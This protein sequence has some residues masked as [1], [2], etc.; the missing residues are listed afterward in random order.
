MK[1][2][3]TVIYWDAC[4]FI[5]WLQDEKDKWPLDVWQGILDAADLI[6]Q[7]NAYLL[8]ST[9]IRTEIFLGRLTLEEKQKFAG[10]LRRRN[11]Q[12][13]APDMRVTDRASTIREKYN[14]LTNKIKTPDAIHLATAIIYRADEM[15]TMDG[16]RE[17][18]KHTGLLALNANVAGYKLLIT[19]PYRRNPIIVPASPMPEMAEDENSLFA[20]GMPELLEEVEEE[21][22]ENGKA[23]TDEPDELEADSSHPPAIRGSDEGRTEGETS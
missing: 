2:G 19:P 17:D 4:V 1:S 3:R 14:T 8:V 7:N 21:M 11:V 5:A 10:M 16:Y 23:E 6:T 13:L 22:R 9:L 18:G 12:E 20:Q 15:Q